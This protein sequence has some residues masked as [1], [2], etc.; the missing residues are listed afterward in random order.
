M[1]GMYGM[2][3]KKGASGVW[4]GLTSVFAS[5]LALVVGATSIAQANAAI[6]NTRLG[7]TNYK[8]VEMAEG[9]AKDSIYF[10]SEFSSLSELIAAKEA[11]AEEIASEGAVLLKNLDAA[12]PLDT[13]A[14]TVTL[15]GLNSVNPTLGGKIGSS[16][17]VAGDQVQYDLVTSLNAKGFKLNQDMLSLYQDGSLTDTY[18]RKSG[19]SLTPSFGK[20]Y[21]NPSSYCVGEAPA[22][23]YTDEALASADGTVALVVFSRDSSEAADYN[24][25]MVPAAAAKKKP[26]ADSYERPL[27][28]T[29]NE[30]AVLELAK[31]HS[32]KVVVLINANNPI[33][34]EELKNDEAV[35]AILWCGEPGMD[36]FLGIADV[37]SGAVNPSG[38][39]FVRCLF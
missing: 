29:E 18:G 9:E 38:D 32:S 25:D 12:L 14:E 36:G 20:I 11:L 24:P 39:T 1:G 8:I 2:K 3:N 34:I 28:L 33:E 19:H 35:G 23:V 4:R 15:W 26:V 22:D 31:A 27:A 37:L 10:K 21:E 6:I 16:V 30:K 7:I 13:G 17:S 5:L